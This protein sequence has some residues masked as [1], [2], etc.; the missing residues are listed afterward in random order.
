ME[1][2]DAE[3]VDLDVQLSVSEHVFSRTQLVMSTVI[4]MCG[5]S[6]WGS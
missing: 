6:Q 2:V 1:L 3:G 5:A 4:W